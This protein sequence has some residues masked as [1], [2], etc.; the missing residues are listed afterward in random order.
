[1]SAPGLSRIGAPWRILHLGLILYMALAALG[2]GRLEAQLEPARDDTGMVGLGLAI[3]RLQTTG[4]VLFVTAHPDDENNAVL[5][6]L[7]RGLGLRV[8]VLTLTRGAGGQNEI[9]PELGEALAVLRTEELLAV[10]RQDRVE[11]LFGSVVDFGYS[12]SVEETLEKW[13]REKTLADI[14]YVLRSFRPDV[15]VTMMP[16]GVGGGQHHQTSARLAQEAFR[17]SGDSERF[18]E[19]GLLPWAPL[20]IYQTPFTL[21]PKD[22]KRAIAIPVGQYD[23]LLGKSYAEHGALARNNHRCQGMNAPPVPGSPP[24][25]VIPVEPRQQ[26]FL[27]DGHECD[28]QHGSAGV[29]CLRSLGTLWRENIGESVP[30]ELTRLAE[31]A[32]ALPTAFRQLDP[33]EVTARILEGLRL[34]QN[35]RAL[36][37]YGPGRRHVRFLLAQ[38]ERDWLDA[39]EVAHHF[40]CRAEVIEL[41]GTS[42]GAADGLVTPGETFVVKTTLVEQGPTTIQDVS[43]E[44]L[45]SS[46]PSDGW[47]TTC[48]SAPAPGP[49]VGPATW[50]HELHVAA[51]AAPTRP[52]W[53][54]PRPDAGR[55]ES[56]HAPRVKSLPF[57]PSIFQVT[58]QYESQGTRA[59]LRRPIVHAFYD[60]R[61]GKH[62]SHA[63][64]VVPGISVA[65]EPRQVILPL[66][67]GG[68]SSTPRA[69]RVTVTNRFPRPTEVRLSFKLPPH[70]QIDPVTQTVAFERENAEKTVLFHVVPP[71]TLAPGTNVVQV[72]AE[73]EGKTYEEGY[74][75]IDYHH[76][77]AR[78]LFEPARTLFQAFRVELPPGLKVG[79][80]MG[81]GDDVP[82]AIEELGGRVTLLGAEE[83]AGGDFSTYDAVVTGVRAYKD[84]QDLIA[85][86][87]RLLDYVKAGGVLIVQYNKYE[88]NR[89][90]YGPYPYTIHKPHDRVT[91]EQAPVRILVP[92]HRMFHAPNQIVPEDWNGWVQER[93]LYFLGSWDKRYVPLLKIQDPFEYNPGTKRGALVV[94]SYGKGV[95]VYTGLSFFRQLPAGIPG[96][97]RLFANLLSLGRKG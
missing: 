93:G 47:T 24:A 32:E 4:S 10:H 17:V 83:L 91:S 31:V 62:R 88:L 2:P 87:T 20:A 23:R 37:V 19:D 54:R 49:L 56:L 64:K 7:S 58:V 13:N 36:R 45:L 73:A 41:A 34:V 90:Q 86:N 21:H 94:A 33:E 65:V 5:S 38:E 12:F 43:A 95:Y 53:R 66:S 50:T 26:R 14:V 63:I 80:V 22:R 52:F 29:G 81:V 55:R 25:W 1:M 40:A 28:G 60:A 89:S 92:D 69:L 82:A 3:R 44:V 11:Q 85:S 8:G 51:D 79:Y 67:D 6:Y 71:P 48:L 35:L 30:P 78:H 16:D 9:G 61:V 96:A 72:Q 97:Y 42:S 59:T 15:V 18:P 39:A 77:Q 68:T 84:R 70:W 75:V 27:F 46:T 74:R 76:I 57:A